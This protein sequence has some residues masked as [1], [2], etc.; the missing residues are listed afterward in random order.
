ME[1]AMSATP[2]DIALQK[3]WSPAIV[4]LSVVVSAMGSY[5]AVIMMDALRN[6]RTRKETQMFAMLGAIATGLC[7]VFCMHF[8]GMLSL[9]LRAQVTLSD[10]MVID[11]TPKWV[12][13]P[14]LTAFSAIA[15]IAATRLA[16]S[17]ALNHFLSKQKKPSNKITRISSHASDLDSSGS[18][19]LPMSEEAEARPHASYLRLF[20]GGT[21]L[22]GGVCVMHFMGMEAMRSR[23]VIMVWNPYHILGSAIYAV[24]ISCVALFLF[25]RFSGALWNFF[26]ALVITTAV[27]VMHYTAM[28]AA[29]YHFRESLYSSQELEEGIS[30]FDV[31]FVIAF[32]AFTTCFILIGVVGVISQ[33]TLTMLDSRVKERTL[34]LEFERLKS[35]QLLFNVLPRRVAIRIRD[36]SGLKHAGDRL[37]QQYQFQDNS[38]PA[39]STTGHMSPVAIEQE[40]EKYPQA[41]VMFVDIVGFTSISSKLPAGNLVH[42]LNGLFSK[43]D[44]VCAAN[45]LEKI[46]T[47]GDAYMCANGLSN[48]VNPDDAVTMVKT[49]IKMIEAAA[50]YCAHRFD[51]PR[52]NVRVGI[53]TGSLVAGVIGTTRLCYDLWGD[54]V[55][56][57]SRMESNGIPGHVQISEDTY[58]MIK[59]DEALAARFTPRMIDVKG[60]GQMVAYVCN[61]ISTLSR[62][63]DTASASESRFSLLADLNV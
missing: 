39:T 56:V 30:S 54:T 34:E 53:N 3:I 19:L 18:E 11:F 38:T 45:N 55:N 1:H 59:H 37:Q 28:L 60:K 44:R 35:E 2:G 47:I 25:D 26:V 36:Q 21:L 42:M 46:K 13:D 12:Y 16:F 33:R 49:G 9:S 62:F 58:E 57:A 63:Y 23:G 6:S 14:T 32:V 61:V 51:I 29:G 20:L 43:F 27:C 8:I 41:S 4:G 10:G 5:T 50:D 7:A 22:G 15:I 31:S 52:F 24:A 40:S 17:I 48:D